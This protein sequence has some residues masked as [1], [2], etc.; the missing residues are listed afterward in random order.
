M[1][2]NVWVVAEQWRG[3]LSEITYEMLALGREVADGLGVPLTAVLAGCGIRRMAQTLGCA[4]SVLYVDHPLLAEPIPE[5]CAEA[6]AQLME[7]RK[8]CALL[9]PLTNVSLGVGTLVSIRLGNTA[10]N[11]CKDIKIVDGKLQAICVMY[12]GKIEVA[13]E[14]A[15]G[16]A[17]VGVWPGS[18]PADKGRSERSPVIEEAAVTLKDSRVRLKK[19]IDPE[20]GDVDLTKQDVLVAVGRGIQSRDN[21]ALAEELAKALGGAVAGSR[22]VIDQGWLPLSRQIGKSGLSVKPKLYVALGI[23]GAPEHIEGM[24]DAGLIVAVNSDARAPIFNVAH[25]GIVGDVMETLP[26]LTEAIEARKT[27][28]HH[29]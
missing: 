7:T 25:Y 20:A 1:T 9:I 22:P 14:T 10:V 15:G 2:G 13:V 16:L 28:G 5:L 6:L 3:Q 23:S 4:D 12:G 27:A 24:K 17:I 29:A 11:F 21:I 18:R 19:Y 26:A 8:P